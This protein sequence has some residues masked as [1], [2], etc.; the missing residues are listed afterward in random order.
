M[1]KQVSDNNGSGVTKQCTKAKQCYIYCYYA[2][3]T[4]LTCIAHTSIVVNAAN[5]R[6]T[7]IAQI[8]I[9]VENQMTR[10]FGVCGQAGKWPR[11]LVLKWS[12][13]SWYKY[14]YVHV[15]CGVCAFVVI[16]SGYILWNW[17]ANCCTHHQYSYITYAAEL[18]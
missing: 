4:A 18:I 3:L 10:Q 2:Q 15:C 5:F 14:S 9:G 12:A 16:M 11:Q 8:R 1:T 6:F 7:N 13:V 17:A